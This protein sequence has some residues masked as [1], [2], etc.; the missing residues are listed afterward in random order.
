MLGGEIM[1]TNETTVD[2]RTPWVWISAMEV[3]DYQPPTWPGNTIPK[4]IHLDLAVD[5]LES[6]TQEALELGAR[7]CDVQPYPDHFRVFLDPAGH[8]FCLTTMI[9]PEARRGAAS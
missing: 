7:L 9:P 4:Q 2:V 3:P 8:P 6:T 1:F 5:D